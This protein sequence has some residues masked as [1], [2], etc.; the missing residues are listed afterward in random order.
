L[1]AGLLIS[2]TLSLGIAFTPEA[3]TSALLSDSTEAALCSEF[4][5]RGS[6]T[7]A[8]FHASAAA[9]TATTTTTST[10]TSA[11]SGIGATGASSEEG[12]GNDTMGI[13]VGIAALLV[14]FAAV[15][16]AKCALMLRSRSQARLMAK[17]H[18]LSTN[19]GRL[20]ESQSDPAFRHPGSPKE[21]ISFEML[22]RREA[23][24]R[25]HA[26]SATSLVTLASMPG[27]EQ[28]S[29][30]QLQVMKAIGKGAFGKV[31]KAA[32][33]HTGGDT[34]VAPK[35]AKFGIRPDAFLD[36][37]EAMPALQFAG[38]LH[39]PNVLRLIAVPTEH[40][41]LVTEYCEHGTMK[42]WLQLAANSTPS[43]CQLHLRLKLL[44]GAAAA[45][46]WVAKEG[47]VHCDVK[48][49][50][51]LIAS[52][53]EDVVAK[54]GDFGLAQ[55]PSKCR[56]CGGRGASWYRAPELLGGGK[57]APSFDGQSP[58]GS[59]STSAASDGE[60]E[61]ALCEHE[62]S[63]LLRPKL[64]DF[65]SYLACAFCSKQGSMDV[66][67]LIDEAD[68]KDPECKRRFV[69][70]LE[71]SW[72]IP[73]MAVNKYGWHV[74]WKVWQLLKKDRMYHAMRVIVKAT[75]NDPVKVA[76]SKVG[77]RLLPGIVADI[78]HLHE[79][80]RWE[81]HKELADLHT[82]V[83]E[84]RAM[85]D[86]ILAH[87]VDLTWNQWGRFVVISL[88]DLCFKVA[89]RQVDG[90]QDHEPD[91]IFRLIEHLRHR[92]ELKELNKASSDIFQ[93][94]VLW[95]TKEEMEEKLWPLFKN[96]LSKL[97]RDLNHGAFVAKAVLIREEEYSTRAIMSEVAKLDEEERSR[98][99][100]KM[101][102][103]DRT[104]TCI[105]EEHVDRLK[106]YLEGLDDEEHWRQ[107]VSEELERSVEALEQAVKTEWTTSEDAL[108]E[109]LAGA[110]EARDILIQSVRPKLVGLAQYQVP[111]SEAE[112]VAV[113]MA[114]HCASPVRESLQREVRN[115]CHN[116]RA[117][118]TQVRD[119][120]SWTAT[121]ETVRIVDEVIRVGIAADQLYDDGSDG[122]SVSSCECFEN[123]GSS[124]CTPIDAV[125]A[126]RSDPWQTVAEDE[127]NV[128]C[129]SGFLTS[130]DVGAAEEQTGSASLCMPQVVVHPVM[131]LEGAVRQNGLALQY[132]PAAC[133]DRDCAFEDSGEFGR[134]SFEHDAIKRLRQDVE[135]FK[136][137]SAALEAQRLP[138]GVLHPLIEPIMCPN[139]KQWLATSQKPLALSDRLRC[140]HEVASALGLLATHGITHCDVKMGSILV[141]EDESGSMRAKLG[142]FGLAHKPSECKGGC[143]RG[144]KVYRAPEVLLARQGCPHSERS[145]IWSFALVMYG[146]L[147]G[148]E[149]TEG[150]FGLHEHDKRD[151][152][153][154]V[155]NGP[156]VSS[157]YSAAL[158]ALFERL[159]PKKWRK[160]M[161]RNLLQLLERGFQH[162]AKRP[163]FSELQESLAK[164][165]AEVTAASKV[166][167]TTM[168]GCSCT[169]LAAAGA[170][171]LDVKNNALGGFGMPG[172]Q[173]GSD[174]DFIIETDKLPDE[175]L[176]ENWPGMGGAASGEVV[177]ATMVCSWWRRLKRAP[178]LLQTAPPAV[179]SD[180]SMVQQAL[181]TNGLALQWADPALC[182]E[183]ELVLTAVQQ[184]GLALEFASARLKDDRSI[185]R[186]AILQNGRAFL[187]CSEEL[188]FDHELAELA[189]LGPA[190][191]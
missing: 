102:M 57:E 33:K 148:E 143:C 36:E 185:A 17:I 2:G 146:L 19:E 169:V 44:H 127:S 117:L 35:V 147:K 170:S 174:W 9:L 66:Q 28:V 22:P 30:E 27:N 110:E 161:K 25:E 23:E 83:D 162:Y 78:I 48:M 182:D 105:D 70:F 120:S 82:L 84:V 158:D 155:S 118:L 56:G 85:K 18:G 191:V 41:W 29:R 91:M 177:S 132:L 137:E 51:I 69:D 166:Q 24:E 160:A 67:A 89:G 113:S 62:A 130:D 104:T 139:L 1:T 99:F 73:S 13:I 184:C 115:C 64:N 103:V 87:A 144:T 156:Q 101:Q 50:N 71:T 128:D 4:A 186:A 187:F 172:M 111:L 121:A 11:D 79:Y 125:E 58:D 151:F 136:K 190:N 134:A 61:E 157:E 109:G 68:H 154:V 65:R 171:A 165:I 94:C 140:L 37:V 45:L 86:S 43:R 72:S 107:G 14:A 168:A 47:I 49:G 95:A 141:R 32:W 183:M 131:A 52:H 20:T 100:K 5:K 188:Q 38:G 16:C 15:L 59:I 7:C 96:Q 138:G 123:D 26:F 164:H 173:Y 93:K 119:T 178:G 108:V 8:V 142:D 145:D 133:I 112:T 98:F 54:L 129:N 135:D 122:C 40:R 176:V 126:R 150:C 12:G 163:S 46:A 10:S 181:Q 180:P 39:H 90:D 76:Q 159:E 189:I 21:T 92:G 34:E 167:V 179:K 153:Q 77:C 31:Y 63:P 60:R 124:L 75:N 88:M 81:S 80:E 42:Q 6:S 74:L 175:A 152:S 97:V 106:A 55:S 114:Q 116:L 3:I 149:V 53:W